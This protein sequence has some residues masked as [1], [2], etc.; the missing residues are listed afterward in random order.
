MLTTKLQQEFARFRNHAHL[1]LSSDF[2]FF[3]HLTLQV[4]KKK[5]TPD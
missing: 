2:F 1:G 3:F 5:A 4:Q